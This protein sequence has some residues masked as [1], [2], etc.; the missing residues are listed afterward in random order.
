MDGGSELGIDVRLTCDVTPAPEPTNLTRRAHIEPINGSK[1]RP[2]MAPA[3]AALCRTE[4][5]IVQLE[6][7]EQGAG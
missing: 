2:I 6:E 1:G 4:T 3:S 7:E 5:N